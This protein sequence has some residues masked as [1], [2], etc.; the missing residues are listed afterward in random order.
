MGNFAWVE[1]DLGEDRLHGKGIEAGYLGEIYAA[2]PVELGSEGQRM[3]DFR[4]ASFPSVS[5]KGEG[6]DR[7]DL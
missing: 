2:Y 1:T 7:I 4:S 5:H 6:K 3:I